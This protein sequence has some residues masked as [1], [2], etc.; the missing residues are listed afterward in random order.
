M[1]EIVRSPDR[2]GVQEDVAHVSQEFGAR[3]PKAVYTLTR[4]RDRLLALVGSPAEHWIHARTTSLIKSPFV[5]VRAR[6][7]V[8]KG[9]GSRKASLA[10]ALNL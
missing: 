3:Y 9:A 4:D 1:H 6:R 7:K 2:H 8:M 10:M 5:T